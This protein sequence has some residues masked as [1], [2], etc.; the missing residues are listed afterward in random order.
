MYLEE[1]KAETEQHIKVGARDLEA[2]GLEESVRLGPAQAQMA[3]G[4]GLP[5]QR[6]PWFGTCIWLVLDLSLPCF[7]TK[8]IRTTQKHLLASQDSVR[9][10]DLAP[11]IT[12]QVYGTSR[13]S[14]SR[15]WGRLISPP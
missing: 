8:L 10:L 9:G 5:S 11:W 1:K 13:R 12:Q 3:V 4:V 7:T 14:R 2:K 6:E 15:E